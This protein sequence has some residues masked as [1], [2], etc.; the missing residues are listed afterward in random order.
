[1]KFKDYSDKVYTNWVF[2]DNKT[3]DNDFEEYKKKELSKW[4]RRAKDLNARFPLFKDKEHYIQSL[5]NSPITLL[6]PSLDN[7]IQNRSQTSSIEELKKLVLSYKRPRDVDRIL[8]EFLQHDKIPYPVILKSNNK[9]FIMSG[10]TRLDVA[11]I[12]GI[13][14]KVIIIDVS[15]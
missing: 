3:I 12:Y 9:Y 11:F 13:I 15:K 1:M 2:P 4:K 8:Q 6:S 14:P 7:K 5:K 10:N